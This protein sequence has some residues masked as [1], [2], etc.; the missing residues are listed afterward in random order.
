M[1]STVLRTGLQRMGLT[2]LSIII[3]IFVG[4]ENNC[5]LFCLNGKCVGTTVSREVLKTH[6]N[7][8]HSKNIAAYVS[9]K[10]VTE[11]DLHP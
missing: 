10:K 4:I 8:F 9:M 6:V 5:N 11:D 3:C 2:L 7:I 1:A